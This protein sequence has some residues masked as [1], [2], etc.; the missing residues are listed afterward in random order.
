[1]LSIVQ[2]GCDEYPSLLDSPNLSHAQG[3]CGGQPDRSRAQVGWLSHHGRRDVLIEGC[4][5]RIRT[6]EM[7]Q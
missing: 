5:P 6:P 1:M 4:E 7:E 2:H 3:T